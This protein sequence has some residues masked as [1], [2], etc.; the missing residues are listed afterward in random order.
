MQMH[1]Y[2]MHFSSH[3]S[4]ELHHVYPGSGSTVHDQCQ[5]C[6]SF[7]LVSRSFVLSMYFHFSSTHV[8]P[9]FIHLYFPEGGALHA[10]LLLC[11]FLF[12]EIEW[13]WHKNTRFSVDFIRARSHL[14]SRFLVRVVSL[15]ATRPDK[16][17]ALA[18]G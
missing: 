12:C 14:M 15:S 18:D 13:F 3:L 5:V 9:S 10:E 2:G 1:G 7:C 17:C 6:A 4:A 16:T 11:F 8:L